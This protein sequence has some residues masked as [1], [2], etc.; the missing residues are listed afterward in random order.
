MCSALPRKL[1]RRRWNA[2][3][4]YGK[5]VNGRMELRYGSC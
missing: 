1:G 4:S 5:D 3:K 2:K